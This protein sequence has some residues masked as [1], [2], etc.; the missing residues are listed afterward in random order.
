M[1]LLTYPRHGN[2]PG[3]II[4]DCFVGVGSFDNQHYTSQLLG[5]VA[6]L[7]RPAIGELGGGSGRFAYFLLREFEQFSYVDFDLPEVL[8]CAAYYLIKTF[9]GKRTLLYGEQPLKTVSLSDYD[10]VFLPPWQIETLRDCSIDLFLN[11]NSLGEMSRDT[12]SHHLAHIARSSHRFFHLNHEYIPQT[13]DG[14]GLLASEYQMP[15][16]TIMRRECDQW[17]VLQNGPESDIFA[18]LFQ[19]FN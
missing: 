3:A 5:L 11:K 8:V 9:P 2:Q 6:R 10:L 1:S 19:R 16:F 14:P 12:A 17:H 4:D 18:Y 15:G 13:G 7:K